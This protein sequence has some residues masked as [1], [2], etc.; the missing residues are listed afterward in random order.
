MNPGSPAPQ[1]GILDHSRQQGNQDPHQLQARLRPLTTSQRPSAQ[2]NIVKTLIKLQS[3]GKAQSTLAHVNYRLT[4]LNRYCNLD[5]PEEV[6][7]FISL[8]K[9]S[10]AY[11]D[12]FV[13]SYNYN[14]KFNGLSC[15]KP[16]YKSERQIPKI[17]T[18]EAINSIIARSSKNYTVI[19]KILMECGM[20]LYELSQISRWQHYIFYRFFADDLLFA[21][22]FTPDSFHLQEETH[23][24]TL[25][26][27]I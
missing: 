24:K 8:L 12:T 10:N 21:Q 4:Y 25:V 23:F 11:K 7:K 2:G 16:V 15:S 5:N 19:F 26:L 20:M 9:V 22:R 18:T 14:V 3:L 1:A 27:L 17:P 6:A 13:K